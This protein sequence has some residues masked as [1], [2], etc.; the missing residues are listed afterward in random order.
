MPAASSG[1]MAL[2]ADAVKAL[3][4]VKADLDKTRLENEELKGQLQASE[5]QLRQQS[6]A[7]HN[8]LEMEPDNS[9]LQEKLDAAL[10]EKN[11]AV[12][13]E[14]AKN[15]RDWGARLKAAKEQ[16]AKLQEELNKSKEGEGGGGG[17]GGGGNEEIV[18]SLKQQ[19]TTLTQNNA[20]GSAVVNELRTK[21]KEL[22]AENEQV[23]VLEDRLKDAG[24]EETRILSD[25]DTA[26]AERDQLVAKLREMEAKSEA[27]QAG[28]GELR[29]Q[30]EVA[31][32]DS[33]NLKKQLESQEKSCE[34][35]ANEREEAR[36]QLVEKESLIAIMQG[37]CDVAARERDA[38]IEE[39][40][41]IVKERDAAAQECNRLKDAESKMS[42]K[43]QKQT[44]SF[45]EMR[46][47]MTGELDAERQKLKAIEARQGGEES[48]RLLGERDGAIAERE[49]LAAKIAEYKEEIDKVKYQLECNEKTCEMVAGERDAAQNNLAENE[50]IC[51]KVQSERDAAV[52]ELENLES[53][54]AQMVE[55]K[56]ERDNLK[57]IHAK[58]QEEL[59]NAGGKEKEVEELKNSVVAMQTKLNEEKEA[60][61]T[62]CV[63]ASESCA[64]AQEE[65]KNLKEQLQTLMAER[66]RQA[67]VSPSTPSSVNNIALQQQLDEARKMVSILTS[68]VGSAEGTNSA[69]RAQLDAATHQISALAQR[70]DRS[71]VDSAM[72]EAKVNAGDVVQREESGGVVNNVNLR[73]EAEMLTSAVKKAGQA[74]ESISGSVNNAV[75]EAT[76]GIGEKID[77]AVGQA[78]GGITGRINSAVGEAVGSIGGRINNAV[79]EAVGGIGA[80]VALNGKLEEAV[81]NTTKIL[82]RK[83]EDL[84]AR[85]ETVNVVPAGSCTSE[86]EGGGGDQG[87][88]N[89]SSE[90]IDRLNARLQTTK[91][92]L[93]QMAS[94]YEKVKVSR[95]ELSEQTEN[96]TKEFDELKMEVT[97]FD[98]RLKSAGIELEKE[99]AEKKALK[100]ACKQLKVIAEKSEAEKLEL[101]KK[102]E[103]S[104]EQKGGGGGGGEGE[105]EGEGEEEEED[106][107]LPPEPPVGDSKQ[108]STPE[109]KQA[110]RKKFADERK[111]MLE[112]A[113]V[114]QRERDNELNKERESMPVDE[115]IGEEDLI[116]YGGVAGGSGGGGNSI[117]GG[118][119]DDADTVPSS[120]NDSRTSSISSSMSALDA[121]EEVVE[122]HPLPPFELKSPVIT[123]LLDSWTADKQKLQYLQLWLQC[124]CDSTKAVPATFPSGLTLLAL[125]P[126]IRDG[127]LTLVVPMLCNR[128][129]I[130]LKVYSRISDG[131][132]EDNDTTWFDLKLKIVF[133]N[134]ISDAKKSAVGG[135]IGESNG[136][137]AK[138]SGDGGDGRGGS[139]TA[140]RSSS[141]GTQQM[142]MKARIQ[143]R[144]DA[145]KK[146]GK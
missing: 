132:G 101:V 83:I 130:D 106:S 13:E 30:L 68:K 26:F 76:S 78:V 35:L 22:M 46:A 110:A 134:R 114:R 145:L 117:G 124:L 17:G 37:E 105:G 66:E 41:V 108:L 53:T 74:V 100:H 119:A 43:L 9:E 116:D 122:R 54:E 103:A 62:D 99:R 51:E 143:A 88:S 42:M 19:V 142:D 31:I 56:E 115:A 129:D 104:T 70:S 93:A 80:R 11:A 2:L 120:M 8:G 20:R 55:I 95:D 137:G 121:W 63:Q 98:A 139:N 59:Q 1:N 64:A 91:D 79:D 111:Q 113:Q 75:G 58:L 138:K 125:A 15:A 97:E 73:I 65:N 140:P 6:L 14:R 126:E 131:G 141:V 94:L 47:K 135:G 144:L 52:K 28:E 61:L 127:F 84:V 16:T 92:E 50:K 3:K 23:A 29:G 90:E 45:E 133:K 39:R 36:K 38:A 33:V 48:S 4:M 27:G 128:P 5:Q 60:A 24:E 87:G 96:T 107:K 34:A 12:K 123:H 71:R 102:F 72:K 109:R 82:E 49:K 57:I 10:E 112:R 86:G 18:L 21:V 77:V 85:L 81:A 118:D 136:G 67:K 32:S 89:D 25:R 69:L 44:A 146:N 40:E 7:H